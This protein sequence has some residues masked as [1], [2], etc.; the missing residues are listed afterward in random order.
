MNFQ[1]PRL[2]SAAIESAA[3]M[4]AVALGACAVILGMISV[5]GASLLCMLILLGLIWS[6]WRN[7]DGGRHP[8]FLFLGMLFIFQCGRLPGFWTGLPRNPFA[9]DGL[10]YFTISQS[11]QNLTLFLIVISALSVYIPCRFTYKKIVFEGGR[12]QRWLKPLYA[13]LTITIPF[14]A[15]KNYIYLEFVRTHG[16]YMAIYLDSHA[17]LQSAGTAVRTLALIGTTVL[18]L[19]YTFERRRRRLKW[20]LLLYLLV[21]VLDLLIG[22]RGKFFVEIVVLWYI[23]NLK[24]GKKF[25]LA[26]LVSAAILVSLIAVLIASFRSDRAIKMISPLGFLSTQGVSLNVTEVAVA[27]RHLFAGKS[28]TY[29]VNE[30][31]LTFLPGEPS[32][33]GGIFDSAVSYYINPISASRGYGTGSTYLA[34]AYLIGAIPGVIIA[35]ILIGLMLSWLHGIS[36]RWWG[37]LLMLISLGWFIYMPRTG[38]LIPLAMTAKSLVVVAIISV[39]A[40]LMSSVLWIFRCGC[41]GGALENLVGIERG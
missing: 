1:K 41:R 33:S 39:L 24:T 29:L 21:S 9:I 6:A 16:G 27:D 36:G 22:L 20:L 11:S 12:E 18:L 30:V 2:L 19:L 38:L 3:W 35:S 40:V 23:R 7:F 8:C 37:A 28:G 5:R 13:L 34:E 32:L 15:Y 4:S 14:A 10:T 31:L 26:P 17:L 25:N